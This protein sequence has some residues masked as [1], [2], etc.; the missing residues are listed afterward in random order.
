MCV[1]PFKAVICKLSGFLPHPQG[2]PDVV[3]TANPSALVGWQFPSRQTICQ[4]PSGAKR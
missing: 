1:Q 4:K 3:A 2:C